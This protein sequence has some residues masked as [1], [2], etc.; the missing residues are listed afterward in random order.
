MP[1][2]INSQYGVP[3]SI[4]DKV[5]K[6]HALYIA[7]EFMG[8]PIDVSYILKDDLS[9]ITDI[10]IS[11]SIEDIIAEYFTPTDVSIHFGKLYPTREALRDAV[12]A[13]YKAANP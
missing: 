13:K 2:K 4:I 9:E 12:I 5:E 7:G 10:P 11:A 3:Q 6:T 1:I 8:Y